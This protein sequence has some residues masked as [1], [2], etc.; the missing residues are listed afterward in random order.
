MSKICSRLL[1][2]EQEIQKKWQMPVLEGAKEK[3][4]DAALYTPD[5]FDASM[6]EEQDAIA[7]R[8]PVHGMRRTGGYRI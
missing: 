7:I 4:A 3:G 6:V 8:M 2:M 5:G 1:E